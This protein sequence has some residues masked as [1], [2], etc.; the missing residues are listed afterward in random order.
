M[1]DKL[2]LVIA[3]LKANKTWDEVSAWL[4]TVAQY[5]ENFQGTVIFCPSHPFISQASE[6]INANGL[7]IKL[8][9]QDIS[10]F[11]QGQ[12]T[13]EVAASQVADLCKYTIIGHSERRQNFKESDEMLSQK[14]QNATEAGITPIF[15]IQSEQTSIPKNVTVVAYEPVEAIGTGHPDTPEDA[16][17]VAHLAKSQ[18]SYTIIYGWSVSADNVKSFITRDL[19][20]GVLVA[21]N[22][23][24]PQNFIKILNS[25]TS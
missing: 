16:R 22:S 7:R 2:P 21:T 12:Y 3:N 6:K 25:I 17:K 18:G 8:S 14:V 4:D 24:D 19:I 10:R 20:D 11:E 1:N 5:A 23:L 9:L 15:C 13:G